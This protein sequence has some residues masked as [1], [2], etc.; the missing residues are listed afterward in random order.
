[1][2]TT[3]ATEFKSTGLDF[4][5]AVQAR[6]ISDASEALMAACTA[7]AA[8]T[9]GAMHIDALRR[10]LPADMSNLTA[11]VRNGNHV[12]AWELMFERQ[13]RRGLIVCPFGVYEVRCGDFSWEAVCSMDLVVSCP[14]N[15]LELSPLK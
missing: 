2:S 5:D 12:D 15:V 3:T 11:C 8:R 14:D 1:M 13:S 9:D 6:R 10:L 4:G 7:A